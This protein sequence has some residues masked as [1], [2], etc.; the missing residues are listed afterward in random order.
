[1]TF[2]EAHRVF[3]YR[4]GALYW[5]IKPSRRDPAGMK[6]GY[7]S[8]VGYVAVNY[9]RKRYYAHRLVYFMHHGFF[10]SEV[11]HIDGNKQNNAI[12]NLRACTHSQ[13]G[14]NKPAQSNNRSGVKNVCWSPQRKKW[15]V[16]LKVDNKNTNFGGYEDLELAELVALE[17]RHKYHKE[18]ARHA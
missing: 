6:A 15:V 9:K 16:Y 10:P 7:T 12:E 1:M 4:D 18:F 11:D 13:N 3:E 5:R 2:D 8:P 14:Q 17:A